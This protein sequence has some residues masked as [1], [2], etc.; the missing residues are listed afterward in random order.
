MPG[1]VLLGIFSLGWLMVHD[2]F[3]R[4]LRLLG[5]CNSL[6]GV[7]VYLSVGERR[8]LSLVSHRYESIV[9]DLAP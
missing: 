9:L 6:V 7:S 1:A 3:S 2:L 5:D 4:E 8:L